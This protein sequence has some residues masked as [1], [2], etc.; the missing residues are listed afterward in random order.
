MINHVEVTSWATSSATLSSIFVSRFILMNPRDLDGK[1]AGQVTLSGGAGDVGA[2]HAGEDGWMASERRAT[3]VFARAGSF[4][5]SVRGP[6]EPSM[7][8]LDD[9]EVGNARQGRVEDKKGGQNESV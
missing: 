8:R 5:D 9:D 4:L 3:I 6:L 7:A 1:D 2:S